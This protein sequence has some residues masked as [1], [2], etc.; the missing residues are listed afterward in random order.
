M[1]ICAA[2]PCSFH[3][4]SSTCCTTFQ[5]K[6]WHRGWADSTARKASR[7]R[8]N[9]GR[10]YRENSVKRGIPAESNLPVIDCYAGGKMVGRGRLE[11]PTT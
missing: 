8:I 1:N 5:V 11:R 7:E 3:L 10:L 4:F 9:P 2:A 6:R